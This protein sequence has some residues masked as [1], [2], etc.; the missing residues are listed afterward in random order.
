[1]SGVGFEPTHITVA[2]LKSAALD[3]SAI[4]PYLIIILSF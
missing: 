2:G 1:M 3:H 4:R